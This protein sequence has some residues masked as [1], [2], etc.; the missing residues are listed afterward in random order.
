MQKLFSPRSIF[1]LVGMI[2]VG[3]L[4]AGWYMQYGPGK[5]QPCPLCIL[6]R[7]TY[8]ILAAVC[9]LAAAHG[10]QRVGLAIYAGIA[11]LCAT[12]GL[13]LS[14]WQINKGASMTSCLD[15]PIGEF[16]NGLP[17]ANWWPEYFFA[18]GGCA[19]KYPPILGLHV[20]QWSLF[21]FAILAALI[22]FILITVMRNKRTP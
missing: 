17:P 9:L 16:V 6:Q 21:W 18:N 5:Q 14:T 2:C 8:L 13:G 1:A 10:P 11:D 20:P 22:T 12:A 7:Y 19:D 3:I 15:D 4:A